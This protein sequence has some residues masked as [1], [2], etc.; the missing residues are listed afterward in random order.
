M[1]LSHSDPENAFFVRKI[2]KSARFSQSEP[3]NAFFVRK[4]KKTAR[5]SHARVPAAA[6]AEYR[7]RPRQNHPLQ[8]F[9]THLFI[10]THKV[11]YR[12]IILKF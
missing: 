1:R 4:I 6:H 9:N 5:F 11:R 7:T 12:D 8:L 2:E 10:Y 3:E